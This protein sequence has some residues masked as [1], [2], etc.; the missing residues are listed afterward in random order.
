MTVPT[1]SAETRLVC[2]KNE[3]GG[4]RQELPSRLQLLIALVGRWVE[5]ENLQPNAL[6]R[7]DVAVNRV[8]P[9]SN[10]SITN[11]FDHFTNSVF[12]RNTGAEAE[13]SLNLRKVNAVVSGVVVITNLFDK[14]PWLAFRHNLAELFECE[15]LRVVTDVE[16]FAAHFGELSFDRAHTG[17]GDVASMHERSPLLAVKHADMFFGHGLSTEQVGD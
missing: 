7:A 10:F 5:L 14:G 8:G 11:R 1:Q 3:S 12:Q 16:N 13:H 17:S 4:S 15:I 6:Q 2:L 9:I